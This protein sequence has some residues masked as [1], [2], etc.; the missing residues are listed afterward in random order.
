MQKK[1]LSTTIYVIAAGAFGAF[2]RWL[3]NQS[4]FE[5]DTGL[6]TKSVFNYLV[7]LVMIAAAVLFRSLIK[8]LK[9]EGL[10]PPKTIAEAFTSKSILYPVAFYT[11]AVVTVI[12]GIATFLEAGAV[13][14]P[15]FYLILGVTGIVCGA[16]F[17]MLCKSARK[18][19]SP[20]TVSFLMTTPVIMFAVWLVSSYKM[21]A[22][23]PTLWSYAVE[24]LAIVAAII[25]FYY[26]AGIAFGRPQGYKGMFGAM[27]GTFM[28][29]TAL[30]DS[31]LLGL[32]LMFLG[33]AMMLAIENALVLLNMKT[34]AEQDEDT[35]RTQEEAPAAAEADRVVIK[36]GEADLRSEPTKTAP[37][38]KK[39]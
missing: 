6:L 16:C 4:A 18:K 1:A 25:A 15:G 36:A 11:A 27:F 5:A 12:G 8:K 19:L 9:A 2:F 13:R 33:S 10:V 26:T 28:C 7:P 37:E 14:F 34:A 22:D 21:N 29:M 20:K 23:H 24:I 35:P 32:Q 30:A 31:R 3:Q 39:R 17:P 38:R